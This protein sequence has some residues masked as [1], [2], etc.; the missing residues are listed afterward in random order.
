MAQS[1]R[2]RAVRR[3][4]AIAEGQRTAAGQ[5]PFNPTLDSSIQRTFPLGQHEGSYSLGLSQQFQTGG[6]R[7]HQIAV[8]DAGI[9]RTRSVISDTERRVAADVATAWYEALFAQDRV[10]LA[11]RNLEVAQQV[12]AAAQARFDAKQIPEVEL[13]LVRLD[14]ERL[15]LELER[16]RSD[17]VLALVR[18]TASLGE[19]GREG[20]LLTGQ[21]TAPE[22]PPVVRA[23]VLDAAV[24]RRPDVKALQHALEGAEAQVGLEEARVWPDVELGLEYQW[25]VDRIGGF[26]DRDHAVGL[27]LRFP[28]PFINRRQGEIAVARAQ[29]E[30]LA[31]DLAAALRQV[32]LEL[33]L[34]L[35]RREIAARTL[36]AYDTRLSSLS[37]RNITELERAYR[38]GEVDTLAVLRAREDFNRVAEGRLEALLEVHRA[39]VELEAAMGGAHE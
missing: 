26:T 10:A 39:R 5:W 25:G 20:L 36:E 11:E 17:R 38:A 12:L 27:E 22:I 32:E 23:Q 24:R 19:P 37:Q 31:A 3:D 16:L 9:E 34:A 2:L 35:Q 29:V 8:A 21:L 18:L 1:P 30:R 33:D 14:R 6:Q 7:G 15:G 13:N 4:L 28:L